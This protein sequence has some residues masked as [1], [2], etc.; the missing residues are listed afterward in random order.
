MT[1]GNLL[2]L[3]VLQTAGAPAPRAPAPAPPP[4]RTVADYPFAVGETFEY[5]V[6]MGMINLGSASMSIVGIDTVRGREAFVFRFAL[7]G[8]VLGY[9][10]NTVLQSWTGVADFV[11]LRFHKDADEDGKVRKTHFEIFPDSGFSREEGQERVHE[12]P[13]AP[14]DDAAFFYFLRTTPFEVGKTYRYARYF[15]KERNP[16]TVRVLKRERIELPDG[17]KVQCLVL[18][19]VIRAKGILSE[20]SDARFW[21]TDDSLRIP[22][23]IRTRF[24]FGTITLRLTEMRLGRAGER[25]AQS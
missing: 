10:I 7:A 11:S 19:P 15:R 20:R 22:V 24:P 16:L 18:H 3:V 23:Q 12:A 1:L 2:A 4:S 14:L 21:V 13:A 6:K 9:D 25:G 5:G 8:G 17:R